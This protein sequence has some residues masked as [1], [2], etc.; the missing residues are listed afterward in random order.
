MKNFEK[1]VPGIRCGL[2]FVLSEHRIHVYGQGG[3]RKA[4]E[5]AVEPCLCL[6]PAAAAVGLYQELQQEFPGTF[7][8]RRGGGT[9]DVPEA[10][11]PQNV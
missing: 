9:A 10:A 11:F 7:F 5:P 6:S 3:C 4:A 1:A 2:F 8:D